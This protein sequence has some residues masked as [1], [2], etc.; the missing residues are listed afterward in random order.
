M[1]EGPGFR[2]H[3]LHGTRTCS[4]ISLAALL[5]ESSGTP[6]TL[7]DENRVVIPRPGH[8]ARGRSPRRSQ[9]RGIYCRLA[10]GRT[11]QPA[12]PLRRRTS[13]TGQCGALRQAT[14]KRK[15]DSSV[16]H[17]VLW[18][19][20]V[21]V[22]RSLGMTVRGGTR[23]FS[24]GGAAPDPLLR[25]HLGATEG[26]GRQYEWAGSEQDL[27][28]SCPRVD[29][30]VAPNRLRIFRRLRVRFLRKSGAC[31]RNSGIHSMLLTASWRFLFPRRISCQ[32]S[33]S[34]HSAAEASLLESAGAESRLSCQP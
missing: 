28:P 8:A 34:V 22:V 11:R 9:G 31:V 14:R 12:P 19:G 6:R 29:P 20:K 32:A 21:P 3:V 5:P 30:L 33:C 2:E 16:A 7:L 15:V 25:K 4:R 27:T 18:S 23:I 10:R 17:P 13:Q 24:S 26:S 1:Q